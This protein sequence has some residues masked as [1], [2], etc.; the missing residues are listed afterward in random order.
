MSYW[1][2]S[3]DYLNWKM[4]WA[5]LTMLCASIPKYDKEGKEITNEPPKMLTGKDLFAKWGKTKR[6]Q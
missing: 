5:N 6:K 2:M 4:S 1:H 3:Y